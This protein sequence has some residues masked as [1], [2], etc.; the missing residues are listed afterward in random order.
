MGRGG[1]ST[2]AIGRSSFK[3]TGRP[4]LTRENSDDLQRDGEA[5]IIAIATYIFARRRAA[6][7][8]LAGNLTIGG[9]ALALR[10]VEMCTPDLLTVQVGAD[11]D[12][13]QSALAQSAELTFQ[14]AGAAQAGID[15]AGAD[16]AIKA[17]DAGVT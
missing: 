15:L 3:E 12:M 10:E 5:A 11:R 17:L 1:F 16:E 2:G 6:N 14:P 4:C 7:C 8:A 13:L 9:K